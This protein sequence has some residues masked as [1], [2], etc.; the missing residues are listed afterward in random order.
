MAKDE[1]ELYE[2]EKEDYA[3]GVWAILAS[4]ATLVGIAS[5]GFES[6]TFWQAILAIAVPT[7]AWIAFFRERYATQMVFVSA[8]VVC[9]VAW[10]VVTIM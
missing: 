7:L 5:Y 9:A 10:F 2:G 6:L 8:S 3:V 1:V 4:V